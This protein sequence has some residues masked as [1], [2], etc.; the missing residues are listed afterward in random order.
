MKTKDE[1]RDELLEYYKIKVKELEGQLAKQKDN[2][3]KLERSFKVAPHDK[4]YLNYLMKS[5][6]S[7]A[8][9]C[10][11]RQDVIEQYQK[12]YAKWGRV[13]SEFENR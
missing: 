3:N 12:H 7:L 6:A 1:I 4:W 2:F 11:E 10:D 8:R 13:Y 5:N 9:E